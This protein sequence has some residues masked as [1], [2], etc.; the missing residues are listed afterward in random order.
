VNMKTE[1][2]HELKFAWL[3]TFLESGMVWLRFYDCTEWQRKFAWVPIRIFEG[4]LNYKTVWL[5]FYFRSR[6]FKHS[7]FN[8]AC[9]DVRGYWM[10][11]ERAE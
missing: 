3:P 11:A 9:P 1:E 10:W 7:Y 4:S 8:G 2:A 5:R 6:F